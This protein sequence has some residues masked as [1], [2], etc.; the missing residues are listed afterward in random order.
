M[1]REL[2]VRNLA[3][4]EEAVLEFG[5]GLNVVTGE[6]GA[7]KS[8]L[9][10]AIELL[11][12]GRASTDVVRHGSPAALIEGR[13]SLEG[14]AAEP[15]RR[16]LRGEELLDNEDEVVISREVRADGRSVARIN[17]RL[18][19]V[20]LL[21]E[22]AEHLVDIHGQSD[23]LSLLHRRVQLELLDEY[24]ALSDLRRNCE[25]VYKRLRESLEQLK[26]VRRNARDVT[27]E[28][29]LLQFELQEIEDADLREGEEE[30]LQAERRRLAHTEQLLQLIQR[31][32]SALGE[33]AYESATALDLIGSAYRDLLEVGRIDEGK[34]ALAE[35]LAIVSEELEAICR[36]LIAYADT[37]EHDPDRLAAIEKRLYVIERLKRKYGSSIAEILDY[38]AD[39]RR[40][41]Q[42]L[43]AQESQEPALLEE[44]ARLVADLRQLAARLT[45]GRATAARKLEAAVRR[46]LADLGFRQAG[47]RVHLVPCRQ[48]PLTLPDGTE[49][50]LGATGAEEVT[51]LVALNPGEPA[52]PLADVAS[53]GETARLMLAIKTALAHVDPVPTVVFDEVDQGVGAR[54]GL[55]V[56]RK[57][58]GLATHHQVL[59]VT[60]LP[61]V[62][63]YAHRHFRVTKSVVRRRTVAE[64]TELTGEERVREIAA[65]IGTTR[66][67]GIATARELLATARS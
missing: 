35:R 55:V 4:F 67:S 60:H 36:Q 31:I 1:L 57:L 41:L 33:G 7:G 51:L 11:V 65:M 53:G 64:V 32:L 13:F 20:G 2:R 27:R 21:R 22:L 8:L 6:T 59:C 26:E 42:E 52:K 10:D 12:G 54:A 18:V 38:A 17:G 48:A 56:G 25:E 46:E 40:R 3:L 39:L 37:L 24:A 43:E 5:P 63:A 15:V 50:R 16:I 9:V 45:E 44:I 47:F 14:V 66:R 30:E 58:H 34:M 19:R 23:H 29:D 49:L 62:A 28:R 61:Q